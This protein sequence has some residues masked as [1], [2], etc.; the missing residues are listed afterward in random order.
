[1]GNKTSH[2]KVPKNQKGFGTMKGVEGP[3]KNEQELAGK[4]YLRLELISIWL[5]IEIYFQF[6]S[7]THLFS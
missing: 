2:E 6:K 1:M 7:Y 4:L 5:D 3:Q